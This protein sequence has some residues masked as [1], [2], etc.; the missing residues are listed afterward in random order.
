MALNRR[1]FVQASLGGGALGLAAGAGGAPER[2]AAPRLDRVS[3]T[4]LRI[5][6][7]EVLRHGDHYFLGTRAGDATGVSVANDRIKYLLPILQ[8]LIIP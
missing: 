8:Q 1:R 6:A 5:T 4:P 2:P 7:V 3:S